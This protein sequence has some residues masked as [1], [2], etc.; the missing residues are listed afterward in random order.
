MHAVL[1]AF[2]TMAIYEELSTM[3]SQ[4]GRQTVSQP[5]SG[6]LIYNN[7]TRAGRDASSVNG[8]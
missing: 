2:A 6:A 1:L 7:R 4:D 8:G 3:E 5:E